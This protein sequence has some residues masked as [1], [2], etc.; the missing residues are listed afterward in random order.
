METEIAA[1]EKSI[2]YR[3]SQVKLLET[4]LTHSSWANEQAEPGG[5]NERMEFLGDAVLELSVTEVLFALFPQ[6]REGELTRMRARLVSKPQL[7][8]LAKELHLDRFLRLGKGEEIQGGRDRS[9]LLSNT[10]EAVLGAIF[11]D[12]GYEAAKSWV[13]ALYDGHWPTTPEMQR[14]KDY[15]SQLQEVTQ[16]LFKE[17][18]VYTLDGSSGPEHSKLFQVKLRLPDGQSLVATGSGVKKAEQ[19]AAQ[20]ALDLLARR[21]Q[22]S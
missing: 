9:S 16:Q 2:H 18:P 21:S 15:K 20:L 4:A 13:I 22:D 11:L 10:L 8:E 6:A 3:F 14:S 17:R 12:Q 7:C 5:H 1:V 19:K